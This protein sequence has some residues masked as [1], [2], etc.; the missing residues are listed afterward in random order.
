[1]KNGDWI[2]WSHW[3]AEGMVGFGQMPMRDVQ[4]KLQEFERA[5]KDVLDSTGADHVLYG[6]KSYDGNEELEEVKFYMLPMDEENF[7]KNVANI[8]NVR[9]YALHK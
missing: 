8:R 7:Q 5:A 1:M 2:R 6:V 4:G 3:T 9:V